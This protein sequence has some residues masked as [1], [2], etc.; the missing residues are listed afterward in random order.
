MSKSGKNRKNSKRTWTEQL[1]VE[2]REQ[3]RLALEKLQNRTNYLKNPRFDA[4]QAQLLTTSSAPQAKEINIKKAAAAMNPIDKVQ[5]SVTCVEHI[6][7]K[8]II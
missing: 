3:E 6:V 8:V 5:V 7:E 1:A 4:A 2:V